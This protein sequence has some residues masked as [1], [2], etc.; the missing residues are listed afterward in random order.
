MHGTGMRLS[1]CLNKSWAELVSFKLSQT[2]DKAR[3][4][5]HSLMDLISWLKRETNSGLEDVMIKYYGSINNVCWHSIIG[6]L[7]LISG[8][9]DLS[10]ALASC[11]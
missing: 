6:S 2:Q 3:Q 8:D 11:L 4:A 10:P 7:F 9:T 1:F 5:T